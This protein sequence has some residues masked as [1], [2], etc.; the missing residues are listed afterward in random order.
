VVTR[1]PH[2]INPAPGDALR[3]QSCLSHGRISHQS[4]DL[5]QREPSLPVA[6]IRQKPESLSREPLA[7]IEDARSRRCI[8]RKPSV[9][10]SFGPPV[11][12]PAGSRYQRFAGPKVRETEGQRDQI[13]RSITSFL[14]V[15]CVFPTNACPAA[16]RTSLLT[17]G[18]LAR[19]PESQRQWRLVLKQSPFFTM[20]TQQNPGGERNLGSKRK[21]HNGE[22]N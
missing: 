5:L 2:C 3:F 18:K 6:P 10:R 22:A 20:P 19:A 9:R 7:R 1:L 11:Q 21:G 15:G 16:T 8:N 4:R 17:P 14:C 13:H 12:W